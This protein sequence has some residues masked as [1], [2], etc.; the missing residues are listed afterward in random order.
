MGLEGTHT[1]SIVHFH[2]LSAFDRGI[3]VVC[4]QRLD[5]RMCTVAFKKHHHNFTRRPSEEKRANMERGKQAQDSVYPK[6]SVVPVQNKN[7]GNSKESV[8]VHGATEELGKS[9]SETHDG[10]CCNQVW[11]LIGGLNK[12]FIPIFE[13]SKTSWKMGK[14]FTNGEWANHLTDQQFPSEYCL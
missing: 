6:D 2:F 12:C 9:C 3:L 10:H 14:H 11:T 4:A 7:S 5:P 1:P 13:M 8:K